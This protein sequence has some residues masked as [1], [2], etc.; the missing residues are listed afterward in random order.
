M[1]RKLMQNP[2]Q[3]K[4][5]FDDF[6]RNVQQGG[7]QNPQQIVQQMLNDGRMSQ[8][9]FNQYRDFANKMTGL[10]F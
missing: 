4:K 2:M 3:F 8:A 9:Q 1:L 7:Q 10:H 5:Q 6:M